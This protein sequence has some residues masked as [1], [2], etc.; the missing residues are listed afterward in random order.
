[1][2]QERCETCRSWMADCK[3]GRGL[4]AHPTVLGP[5]KASAWCGEYQERQP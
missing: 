5:R 3:R 1:M 2:T 4:C